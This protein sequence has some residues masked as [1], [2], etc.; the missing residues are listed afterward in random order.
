MKKPRTP[1]ILHFQATERC[2]LACPGCYLPERS[3]M[4]VQPEE[5]AR[6][7]FRPLAATGV[8][9]ATITGGEPLLHPRIEEICAEACRAFASVQVVCNGLLLTP[10]TFAGLRRAGVRAV[11]VSL[12]GATSEVHDGLRGMRGAFERTVG[13]LRAVAALPRSERS[14]V[15]LG[16]IATAQAANA[17]EISAIAALASAIGLDHFL[18]QPHHPYGFV[19]PRRGNAPAQAGLPPETLQRLLGE[20]GKVA[21]IKRDHPDFVDNSLEMLEAFRDFFILPGGPRQM[22][23]A[24]SFVFVN[25]R[26][27]VRGCLFC[28]PL[29]SLEGSTPAEV[30]ASRAWRDFQDFRRSCRLCLMGCQFRGKAQRLAD[31][32]FAL[33]GEGQAGR[34]ERLFRASL[35]RGPSVEAE[36]G[37]GMSLK[38]MGRIQEAAGHFRNVLALRPDHV[39]SLGDLGEC[40]RMMGENGEAVALLEP[41][42]RSGMATAFVR[43]QYGMALMAL[44]RFGEA[45]DQIMQAVREDPRS[46]WMRFEA[47]SA[48]NSMGRHDEAREQLRRAE[49]AFRDLVGEH[50][51]DMAVRGDLVHCLCLQG[52]HAE[53]AKELESSPEAGAMPARARH[54]YGVALMALNRHADALAH[55]DRAAQEEKHSAWN[56]FDVGMCLKALGRMEEAVAHYETAAE[57]DRSVPWFPYRLGLTLAGLGRREEGLVMLRRAA[58]LA[59]GEARINMELGRLLRLMGDPGA[60]RYLNEASRLDPVLMEKEFPQGF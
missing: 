45:L 14:G 58:A 4:G 1:R 3:G 36:Q 13:N 31:R 56:R 51:E 32:G 52:R 54:S 17:G 2:N 41:S 26:M 60:S 10:E 47:I 27:E 57:L 44:G 39:F 40:L 30:F 35:E 43:C 23:G 46:T 9:S 6:R 24:D 33:C 25:S 7:V 20:M 37:L 21:Q 59:P 50:P 18:V 55:L 28:E 34:A 42:V 8:E 29:A 11:R 5:A 53:A 49:R 38:M 15:E 48:L 16:V 19:Y 22:C 12:D